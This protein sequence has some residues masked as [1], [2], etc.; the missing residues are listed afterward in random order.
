MGKLVGEDR[1]DGGFVVYVMREVHVDRVRADFW[2]LGRV[3]SREVLV[4]DE[5]WAMRRR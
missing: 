2:V 3:Y 5:Y 1:K 4:L